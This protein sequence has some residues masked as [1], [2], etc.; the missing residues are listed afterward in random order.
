MLAGGSAGLTRWCGVC[1]LAG[2]AAVLLG[3]SVCEAGNLHFSY[4]PALKQVADPIDDGLWD[5]TSELQS[6]HELATDGELFLDE[7]TPVLP[8]RLQDVAS[9]GEGG[10]TSASVGGSGGSVQAAKGLLSER[11]NAV[12]LAAAGPLWLDLALLAPSANPLGVLDPPRGADV[13]V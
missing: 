10:A 9:T 5:F 7:E 8:V 2:L 1:L 12:A 13:R 6:I 4:V 11:L 3:G